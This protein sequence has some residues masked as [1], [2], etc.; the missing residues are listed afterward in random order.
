MTRKLDFIEPVNLNIVEG[1]R[2]KRSVALNPSIVIINVKLG[3][4][5]YI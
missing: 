1:F 3:F 5:G 2:A 4:R